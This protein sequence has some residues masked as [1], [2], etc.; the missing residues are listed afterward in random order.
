MK[1]LSKYIMML[2]LFT[3]MLGISACSSDDH[4]NPEPELPSYIAEKVE[5]RIGSQTFILSLFDNVTG[6]AF[7]EL[8]PMT[9]SMEDINSNEKFYRL[10][11]TLPGT[12]ANP[13]IIHAGDLM[14]YG[15]NGLVLFYKTFP[16]SYS[17]ARIGT[18]DNPSALE[19]A[20]DSGTITISFMKH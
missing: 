9:V 15:G 17:Y 16:T 3:V 20:V 7:R 14:A 2:L 5:V 10:P 1:R 13:E 12:V 4:E 18:I 6:R 8:L 19:S 11:E